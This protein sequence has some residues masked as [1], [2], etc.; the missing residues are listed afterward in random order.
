MAK[1]TIYDTRGYPHEVNLGGTLTATDVDAQT[2]TLTVAQI[3]A[4][5][6]VHTSVTGAGDVTTDTAANII[7]GS[8][9]G[10]VLWANDDTEVCYYINDG[11]K[12]LTLVGGTGVTVADDGQTITENEAAVLLFRRTSATTVTVYIIG[13]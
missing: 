11:N 2:N 4:G 1:T 8:G 9:G 3:V 12:T 13:A 5:I 10:G 7:M 6:V